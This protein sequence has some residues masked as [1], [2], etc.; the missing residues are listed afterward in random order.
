MKGSSLQSTGRMMS[1]K[2]D[3]HG[4]SCQPQLWFCPTYEQL[5]EAIA[6]GLP[7]GPSH[8]PP[9]L[10]IVELGPLLTATYQPTP[11]CSMCQQ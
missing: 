8:R 2:L 1:Q 6:T 7:C 4:T 11:Y 9:S 5:T 3:G 10:M